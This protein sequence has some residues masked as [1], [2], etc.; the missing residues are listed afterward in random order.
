MTTNLTK[1]G[2]KD[3]CGAA[4][5]L[6][7]PCAAVCWVCAGLPQ[8]DRAAESSKDM[9]AAHRWSTEGRCRGMVEHQ[10]HLGVSDMSDSYPPK[11]CTEGFP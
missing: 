7:R 10:Q 1:L 2:E 6:G 4:S 3:T 9:E 8:A 11:P 5:S